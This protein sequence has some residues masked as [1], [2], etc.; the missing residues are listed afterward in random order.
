MSP[1][2]PLLLLASLA[3]TACV[4]PPQRRPIERRPDKAELYGDAALVP[5]REGERARR[6]LARAGEI[7]RAV[8]LLPEIRRV[9]VDV[10]M[11]DANDVR[12]VLIV[13]EAE[14]QTDPAVVRGDVQRVVTTVLDPSQATATEVIVHAA[15]SDEPDRELSWPLLLTMLA[16]GVSL[17][18]SYERGRRV[19]AR[20]LRSAR[21]RPSGE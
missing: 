1:W 2:T 17:G 21:R 9:R 8:A 5:T 7:E 6:E 13:I 18:V 16:L 19:L 4:E 3:L 20:S 15:E 14:P 12:A 10:E 11:T